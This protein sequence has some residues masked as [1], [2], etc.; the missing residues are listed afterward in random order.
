M[1][2]QAQNQDQDSNFSIPKIPSGTGIGERGWQAAVAEVRR[3]ASTSSCFW[4]VWRVVSRRHL[5]RYAGSGCPACGRVYAA[6]W[7]VYEASGGRGGPLVP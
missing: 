5:K 4:E 3:L 1:D 7:R 6:L 2:R